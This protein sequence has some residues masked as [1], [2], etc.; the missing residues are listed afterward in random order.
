MI[1]MR[2][3]KY[4]KICE[5]GFYDT[6]LDLINPAPS[7]NPLN[8]PFDPL[9][10]ATWCLRYATV[11][12]G[13]QVTYGVVLALF[14]FKPG[15]LDVALPIRKPYR[16]CTRRAD[17]RYYLYLWILPIFVRFPAVDIVFRCYY[18]P[19][20]DEGCLSPVALHLLYVD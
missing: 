3:A 20:P 1:S 7:L 9:N 18:Q 19:P 17:L 12:L 15:T 11:C 5:Y 8:P 16:T 6:T 13:R 2:F 10:P 4:R 14:E